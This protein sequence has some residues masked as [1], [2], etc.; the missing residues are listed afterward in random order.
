MMTARA[1]IELVPTTT[2]TDDRNETDHGAAGARKI[3]SPRLLH[4][5]IRIDTALAMAE[6]GHL[7]IPTKQALAPTT[8]DKVVNVVLRASARAKDLGLGV[9]IIARGT[10]VQHAGAN[11]GKLRQ[12]VE[13]E[14][15]ACRR[16]LIGVRH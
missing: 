2:L 12:W 1:H 11:R 7:V 13:S 15:S 4:N 10:I 9:A 8:H 6:V 16:H 14:E 3:D 5:V